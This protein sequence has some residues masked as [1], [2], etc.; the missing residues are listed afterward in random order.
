M[1]Q[2]YLTYAYLTA[3]ER[4]K[5]FLPPL[6]ASEQELAIFWGGIKAI[7]GEQPDSLA[8]PDDGAL[9]G[10][11]PLSITERSEI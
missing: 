2:E 6:D 7:K 9:S 8:L 1:R 10:S 4:D 5:V 3:E 11:A